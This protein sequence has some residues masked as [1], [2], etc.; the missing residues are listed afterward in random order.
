MD[1]GNGRRRGDGAPKWRPLASVAR[2]RLPHRAG[3]AGDMQ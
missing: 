2:R 1:P 3:P